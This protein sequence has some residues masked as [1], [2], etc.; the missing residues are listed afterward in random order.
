ME[1]GRIEEARNS[2]LYLRDAT[3]SDIE[4]MDELEVI[5]CSVEEH[6]VATSQSF[7]V[8]FTNKSLFRRLWRAALLQFMAQMCGNTAMK[9]YLVPILMELGVRRQL[10]LMMGGIESTLKIGCTIIEM[11]LIDRLGRRNTL[12]IGCLVM[13]AALAVC[14]L[15]MIGIFNA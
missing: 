4:V 7:T 12:V 15:L 3:D 9:Y 2:L 14:L 13:G 5:K 11:Y 10:A 6:K 1:K 8:L